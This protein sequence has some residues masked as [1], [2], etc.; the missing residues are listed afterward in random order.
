MSR[1]PQHFDPAQWGRGWQTAESDDGREPGVKC[2][3]FMNVPPLCHNYCPEPLEQVMNRL[4][5]RQPEI[6]L[7]KQ[8]RVPSGPHLG[9]GPRLEPRPLRRM[10][11]NDPNLL[12]R[13]VLSSRAYASL[14]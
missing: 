11:L 13:H 9:Q 10:E 3:G 4:T 14:C 5:Q 2:Y 12:S 6:I 7:V 1:G 8:L